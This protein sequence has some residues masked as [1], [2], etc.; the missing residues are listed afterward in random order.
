M[1]A[2]RNVGYFRRPVIVVRVK[3]FW[4]PGIHLS[5]LR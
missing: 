5:T 3:V 1:E 2:A 4:T